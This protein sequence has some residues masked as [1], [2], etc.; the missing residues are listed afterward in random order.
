MTS[1]FTKQFLVFGF[2]V[3]ICQLV[4]T[5]QK[6]YQDI[7]FKKIDSLVNIQYGKAINIKGEEEKLLLDVFLITKE[8]KVRYRPLLI[9]I[10]GGGFSAKSKSTD[11]STIIC[12]KFAQKGYVT[13]TIDYRLGV[14]EP[15]GNV[16]YL[17]A[18]YRAQQ[19]AKAA[20]RYFRNNSELYGIDKSQI[21]IAGASAG[22]M[23]ALA[24]AYMDAT[25]VP[26][27]INKNKWGDLDGTSGNA[28]AS[29][30][31]QGVLNCWGALPNLSWLQKNDVPL[32]NT[33]GTEDKTVPY[34]SSYD[35]HGFKY[36]GFTLFEQCQKLGIATGWLPFD[37]AGHSLNGNAKKY[38]SCADA[39]SN[40]LSQHLDFNH[41][42]KSIPLF[43]D[44]KK[45]NTQKPAIILAN[46][47][48][49]IGRAHV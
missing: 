32:F 33:A 19:D 25:E 1:N 12:T 31:V 13:A 17:E 23:T 28:G 40:W 30:K 44:V 2:I 45:V 18:L 49:E 9:F 26:N 39:M 35:W 11:L 42:Q 36:G 43:I 10:H 16:Q 22:G 6:R 27:S 7:L 29:S 41:Q 46:M 34:D 15:K 20:V 24:V 48:K 14:E 21:F 3:M 47:E 8:D 4:A 5:G 37:G 38:D